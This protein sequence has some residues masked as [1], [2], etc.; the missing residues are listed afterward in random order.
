MKR[1]TALI[2][3]AL[4]SGTSLI[5]YGGYKWVRLNSMPDLSKLKGYRDLISSLVD[6]II[7]ET[8][9][10]GAKAVGVHDFVIKM[11]TDCTEIK[12]QNK[13]ID[14]LNELKSYTVQEFGKSFEICSLLE[15]TKI[16]SYFEKKD[17]PLPGLIGKAQIRYL[18]K[19]FFITLKEYS[20]I[21][22]FTSQVGATQALRYSLVPARYIACMPY[23][24]HEKG[25]ATY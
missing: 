8:E 23:L 24:T 13:F 15:R 7:P 16:L 1:R 2:C 19:P 18:G 3:I 14:G 21:G 9:T 10:P 4:A 5:T 22:Y 6:T 25:W 12:S 11:V 17:K 20:S